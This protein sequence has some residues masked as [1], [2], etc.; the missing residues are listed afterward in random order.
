M[1]QIPAPLAGVNTVQVGRSP[2]HVAISPDS[3]KAYIANHADGDVS[4]IAVASLQEIARVKVGRGP[5]GIGVWG[6]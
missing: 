1:Q 3:Q 6:S 4:V 5:H 2:H